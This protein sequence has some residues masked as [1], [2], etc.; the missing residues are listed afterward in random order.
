MTLSGVIAVWLILINGITVAAFG[1]DKRRAEMREWRIPE[2]TLLKLA[3]I[4]GSPGAKLAQWRFRH[5]TRKRPFAGRLNLIVALQIAALA[6]WIA[7]GW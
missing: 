7:L 1:I 2:H 4:G 5:K 3:L 6:A